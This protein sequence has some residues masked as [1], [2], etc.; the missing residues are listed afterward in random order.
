[1]TIQG[2]EDRCCKKDKSHAHTATRLKRATSSCK[3]TLSSLLSMNDQ[4]E[5][6]LCGSIMLQ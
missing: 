2:L 4:F 3:G 6:K 5:Y 1:M